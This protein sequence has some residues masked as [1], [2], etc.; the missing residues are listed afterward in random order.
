MPA[1]T[2]A[3]AALSTRMDTILVAGGCVL[4]GQKSVHHQV[5]L[6]VQMLL[7]RH[8][9]TE[10]GMLRAGDKQDKGCTR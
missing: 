1:S 7:E 2:A 10:S 3:T 8:D 9:R 6:A 4:K 5:R